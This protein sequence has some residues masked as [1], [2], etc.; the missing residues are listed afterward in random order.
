MK[1]L[2]LEPCETKLSPQELSRVNPFWNSAYLDS[3]A[4]VFRVCLALIQFHFVLFK[5]SHQSLQG[6]TEKSVLMKYYVPAKKTSLKLWPTICWMSCSDRAFLLVCS[7]WVFS[8][9]SVVSSI[10]RIRPE[11]PSLYC[12]STEPIISRSACLQE[13][14][15]KMF[16]SGPN[17]PHPHFLSHRYPWA[18]LLFHFITLLQGKELTVSPFVCVLHPISLWVAG[19]SPGSAPA[20]DCAQHAA[21]WAG[22]LLHVPAAPP[23]SETGRC[24]PAPSPLNAISE[25]K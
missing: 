24:G 16:I 15:I 4:V 5:L 25:K 13:I 21:D 6:Y 19:L 2:F 12:C 11:W 14:H 10:Q 18:H 1:S 23:S 7:G 8:C 3:S 9:F 22:R 20:Q 17:K